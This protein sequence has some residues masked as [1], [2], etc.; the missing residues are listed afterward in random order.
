MKKLW[1]LSEKFCFI[2]ILDPI[3]DPTKSCRS[4]RIR[5]R[6]TDE[7]GPVIIVMCVFP[8]GWAQSEPGCV[9][10]AGARGGNHSHQ[11]HSSPLVR[12]RPTRLQDQVP[13]CTLQYPYMITKKN[14]GEVT[15]PEWSFPDPDSITV[16]SHQAHSSPLVGS[17]PTR[18]QDQVP[19]STLQCM[20]TANP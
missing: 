12:S 18:L 17:R 11:A 16:H 6:N 13:N 8:V 5:I 2:F 15:D 4:G 19:Y 9:C 3:P 1:I 10:G 20:I 14:P 7:Q